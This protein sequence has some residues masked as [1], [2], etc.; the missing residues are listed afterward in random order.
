MF[1]VLGEKRV[2][3]PARMG[4]QGLHGTGSEEACC[5]GVGPR[6]GHGAD[7]GGDATP[8]QA[9]LM[10]QQLFIEIVESAL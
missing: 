3:Y 6:T 10:D 1:Q 4:L 8:S 5:L 9:V 2:R 7:H